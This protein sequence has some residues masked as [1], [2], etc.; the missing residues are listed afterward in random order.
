MNVESNK[1][2]EKKAKGLRT[3]EVGTSCTNKGICI[4]LSKWGKVWQTHNKS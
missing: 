2:R 4:K 3:R 1:R